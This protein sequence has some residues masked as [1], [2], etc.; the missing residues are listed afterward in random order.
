MR[1]TYLTSDNPTVV[2]RLRKDC[3]EYARQR[4]LEEWFENIHHVRL[5][6]KEDA[7]GKRTVEGVEAV[8]SKETLT[9]QGKGDLK[10]YWLMPMNGVY[11]PC[12]NNVE[13]WRMLRQFEWRPDPLPGIVS[14]YTYTPYVDMFIE[15]DKAYLSMPV[16][17]WDDSLW[18]KSTKGTFRKA[19]ERLND[20]ASGDDR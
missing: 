19:E 9:I 10:G 12:K 11:K 18:H 20:G 3:R 2:N 7:D 15:D 17:S 13:V 8:M 1:Q 16:E 6:W 14:S 4:E 5:A